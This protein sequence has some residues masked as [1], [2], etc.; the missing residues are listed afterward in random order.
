MSHPSNPK[1]GSL[2]APG[3]VCRPSGTHRLFFNHRGL[4]PPQCTKI[5]CIGD[6]GRPRLQVI[7]SLPTPSVQ[8]R[9]ARGISFIV[10][11]PC[12]CASAY[13]VWSWSDA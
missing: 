4:P 12:G 13:G 8:K 1:P 6:P 9:A 7:P 10:A 3:W 5:A 2:G 11:P